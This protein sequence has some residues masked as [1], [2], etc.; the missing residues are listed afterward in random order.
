MAKKALETLK[1]PLLEIFGER[2]CFNEIELSL[3]SRDINVLPDFV[4]EKINS[5]PDAVVQP[6]SVE[7]LERLLRF[8][9]E[10]EIPVVPRGAATSGYGGAVPSRG[11]VVVD[12]CRLNRVIEIN[13]QEKTVEVEPGVVWNSL[14]RILNSRGLALRLYPNSGISATVGGWVANGGGVGIGSYE[15][16]TFREDLT[17]A[18]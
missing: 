17:S 10:N 11:G 18:K 1:E 15:F 4:M 8:C 14:D 2:A 13:E 7:E 5:K 6:E 9:Y 16:G 12:F 3:Y